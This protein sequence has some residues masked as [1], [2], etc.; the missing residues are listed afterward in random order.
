MT[1]ATTEVTTQGDVA[2]HPKAC[3]KLTTWRLIRQLLIDCSISLTYALPVAVPENITTTVDITDAN[4]VHHPISTPQ[5]SK[6]I[7]HIK[8][9][10][11]SSW[12]HYDDSQDAQVRVTASVSN[13]VYLLA[14]HFRIHGTNWQQSLLNDLFA[15]LRASAVS[16]SLTCKA[17]LQSHVPHDLHRWNVCLQRRNKRNKPAGS[18]ERPSPET[19]WLRKMLLVKTQFW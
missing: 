12:T 19:N 9:I 14:S 13:M 16:E 3:L 17:N 7:E 2:T 4:R 18:L 10:Q 1:L 5:I 15:R 6:S 11:I 8:Y